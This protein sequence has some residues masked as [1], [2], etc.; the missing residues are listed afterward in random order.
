MTEELTGEAIEHPFQP[1]YDHLTATAFAHPDIMF[2]VVHADFHVWLEQRMNSYASN[3]GDNII[4]HQ[5]LMVLQVE[6]D[7]RAVTMFAKLTVN[8]DDFNPVTAHQIW[9]QSA[10]DEAPYGHAFIKYS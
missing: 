1:L 2:Y 5:N 9:S 6:G 7:S 10:Y 8:P 4:T 3:I